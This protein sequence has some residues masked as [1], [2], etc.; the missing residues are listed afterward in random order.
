MSNYHGIE[1]FVLKFQTAKNQNSKEIRMSIHE[2]ERLSTAISLVL[3][4]ELS[5]SSKI[6]DLQNQIIELQKSEQIDISFEG[7]NF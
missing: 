1:E 4:R 3:A 2:A 6:L 5:L 7:G